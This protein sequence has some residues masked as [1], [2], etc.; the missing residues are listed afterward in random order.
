MIPT[1]ALSPAFR[2]KHL[3][4]LIIVMLSLGEISKDHPLRGRNR[5][6]N[7]DSSIFTPES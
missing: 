5:E 2:E 6:L 4:I 3:I 7:L 1:V